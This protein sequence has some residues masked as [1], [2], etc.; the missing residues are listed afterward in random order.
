M[1]HSP[2]RKRN[3]ISSWPSEVDATNRY[4]LPITVG[5]VGGDLVKPHD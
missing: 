1:E 5:G 3:Y 2:I 4:G